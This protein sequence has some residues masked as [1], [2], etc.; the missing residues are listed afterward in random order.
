MRWSDVN[1]KPNDRM[2]RQFALL[3]LVVFGALAAWQW[4]QHH[5]TAA[6]VFAALA[7]GLGP[8]GLVRPQVLRPVFVG[9]TICAFP[10]GW[11]VSHLV[12][13]LMFY[14]LMLP[15]AVVFRLMNRDALLLQRGHGTSYW[16][17]KPRTTDLRRYFRQ[18]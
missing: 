18:F 15:V 7:V 1:L 9:W 12:L 17:A 13:G 11:V 2:L 4:S 3:C 10:I 16:R 6:S 14:G 5:R 8:I